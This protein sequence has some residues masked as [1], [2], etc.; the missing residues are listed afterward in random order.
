MGVSGGAGEKIQS[1]VQQALES[2]WE[3]PRPS[4]QTGFKCLPFTS[5]VLHTHSTSPTA[6]TPGRHCQEEGTGLS[7]QILSQEPARG[8]SNHRKPT[9]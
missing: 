4:P 8:V 6:V 1:F 7:K 2:P 3:L 9:L 5:H